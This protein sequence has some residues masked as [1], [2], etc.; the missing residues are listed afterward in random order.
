MKTKIKFS[1]RNYL[2]L[3]I[4]F[5]FIILSFSGELIA[6]T[7]VVGYFTHYRR[8]IYPADSIQLGNVTH[9]NHSFAW[10]NADGS[11]YTP[12]GFLYPALNAKIHDAGKKILLC[13]GSDGISTFANFGN[14]LANSKLRATFINNIKNYLIANNYDGADFDWESPA[15]STDRTNYLLF[16]SAL[17]IA[18]NSAN[19]QLLITMAVTIDDYYGQWCNYESMTQYIDWYNMMGY[20]IHGSWIS[21]VGHNAPL[22]PSKDMHGCGS[23]NDGINYLNVYR[24][25]PKNKIVLGI[26]FYGYEYTEAT[27]Y[28][29]TYKTVTQL[30]YSQI[31]AEV[32][33]GGFVYHWDSGSEVPYYVNTSTSKFISFDDTTS[34]HAKV[35]Y[36]VGQ[37]L[38]GISIWE[39][40]NDLVS[41]HQPLLEVIGKALLNSVPTVNLPSKVKLVTPANGVLNQPLK[42]TLSWNKATYA[43][44]YLL[45]LAKDVNFT[46]LVIN[47]AITTD[48]SITVQINNRNIKFFWRVTASNNSGAGQWSNIWNFTTAFWAPNMLN[49]ALDQSQQIILTWKK[50]LNTLREYKIERKSSL[51]F[52][53]II[54]DSVSADLTS[55][56]DKSVNVG[57][58]YDY[59]IKGVSDLTVNDFRNQ[60][61]IAANTKS[62][63]VPDTYALL[64]N[65]PNPFNPSTLISYQ[66]AFLSKVQ[67]KV[68]DNLGKEIT[69][70]VNGQ[71]PAGKYQITW[72]GTD[73]F[74]N[75]VTSGVYFYRINTDN[76]VQ[77]KKMILM[78]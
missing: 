50:S 22:Y 3:I 42:L 56:I 16:I 57:I 28:L 40:D 69:T 74:G 77:T 63:S 43:Q 21:H 7:K 5:L 53:F 12:S 17:R 6:Q 47:N 44:N 35:N 18:F 23:V 4:S 27:R 60:V 70:L 64:Q 26:P 52:D 58:L 48:T 62:E 41:G 34:I 30:S 31:L 38:A 75:K 8:N 36:S 13:F 51:D 67:I 10:A 59:R 72:N 78:K 25:I 76:F 39:L 33:S 29:S 14:V 11:V 61:T 24:S 15:N 65:Y 37:G 1:N 54:I 45:Q 71:K 68:Y 2:D 32:N 73:D 20:D 46:N 49:T 66:L 9:I 55:Y 19:S